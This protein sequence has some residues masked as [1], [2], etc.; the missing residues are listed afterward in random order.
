MVPA[1]SLSVTVTLSML[2]PL[3]PELKSLSNIVPSPVPVFICVKVV[4]K[5]SKT[6]VKFSVGSIT[7]SP[8]IGT[9]IV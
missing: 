8:V 1:A 3:V 2:K 9:S 4:L 7:V 5:P 6:T